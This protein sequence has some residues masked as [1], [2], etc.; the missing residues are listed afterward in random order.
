MER[1]KNGRDLTIRVQRPWLNNGLPQFCVSDFDAG[2]YSLHDLG[3]LPQ[4]SASVSLPFTASCKP[5]SPDTDSEQRLLDRV[6]RGSRTAAGALFARYSSWLRRWA[7]GRLPQWARNGE[8]TSD[9]VQEALQHTFAR[10][11]NFRSSHVTALRSYLKRAIQNRIGDQLRH[12]TIGHHLALP[13]ESIRLTNEAPPQLQ[14]LLDDENWERYL[15]GLKQLTPR[16]QRL[17]VGRVEFGYSYRQ[18]ALIERMATPDA[19]RM[20]FRRALV[21]LSEVMPD[22]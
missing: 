9:L 7:K 18:L 1:L 13:N 12:A 2:A 6:Q 22:A 17:V 20:A 5:A 10:L 14:Q 19:A 21:R 11:E 4:L 15:K 16:H 3:F 8:D